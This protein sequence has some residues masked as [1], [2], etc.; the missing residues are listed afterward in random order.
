MF[1][2]PS[3]YL[4]HRRAGIIQSS[5]NDFQ[6]D[7]CLAQISKQDDRHDLRLSD[8]F[9][10]I[11]RAQTQIGKFR[12]WLNFRLQSMPLL[13]G[14]KRLSVDLTTKQVGWQDDV[15]PTDLLGLFLLFAAVTGLYV[16]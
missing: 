6:R 11:S 13:S 8:T 16:S 3:V 2:S 14:V 4:S 15:N 9:R 12:S 5:N 10:L 7:S 1:Y